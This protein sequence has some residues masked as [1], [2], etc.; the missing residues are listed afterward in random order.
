MYVCLLVCMY[1][2]MYVFLYIFL[3]LFCLHV[4]MFFSLCVRLYVCLHVLMFVCIC[5]FILVWIHVCMFVCMYTHWLSLSLSPSLS[6]SVCHSSARAVSLLLVPNRFDGCITWW[7]ENGSTA[8]QC[9][10]LH[11]STVWKLLRTATHCNTLQHTATHCNRWF[12]IWRV[13]HCWYPARLTRPLVFIASGSG[14][15][16]MRRVLM[17]QFAV[18]CSALPCVAAAWGLSGCHELRCV[19]VW[20]SVYIYIHIY[21]YVYIYIYIY[22]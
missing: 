5:V 6:L 10:T 12:V 15:K 17:P 20:C 18:C 7:T 11:L 1:V 3:F 13:R 8:R 2:C 14:W 19:A 22:I 21:Y 16:C 4:C 9:K